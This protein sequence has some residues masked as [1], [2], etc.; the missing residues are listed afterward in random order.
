MRPLLALVLLAA[1]AHAAGD[2]AS[3]TAGMDC[4]ACHTSAGWQMAP[5]KG[6]GFDHARTGFPLVGAHRA[7]ACNACHDGRERIGVEC[8]GCHADAHAGRLDGACA[9]CHTAVAWSDVRTLAAH[10]RTHLPLTGKHA[11]IECSACHIARAGKTWSDVPW[12][13][14]ACHARDYQRSDIHPS[15]VGPP[16]FPRACASCHRASTWAEATLDPSMLPRALTQA[17]TASHD[18]RFPLSGKHRGLG[19]PTCHIDAAVPARVA[20]AGCHA[21][22]VAT[23]PKLHR[24]RSVGGDCLGCHPRGAPR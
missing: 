9:D 11:I 1:T 14:Y 2:H 4:S 24:A 3:L 22:D 23:L 16:A 12:E 5:G 7:T 21:H 17:S 19:C 18:A 6:G 13:C 15:H 10:R 20:C 8:A